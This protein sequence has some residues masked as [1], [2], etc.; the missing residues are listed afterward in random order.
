MAPYRVQAL[1][2]AGPVRYREM[3]YDSSVSRSKAAEEEEEEE[4]GRMETE[5]EVTLE[6]RVTLRWEWGEQEGGVA[7]DDGVE[8]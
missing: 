8:I 6:G 2:E 1:M 3:L 7:A 5:R 4:Q